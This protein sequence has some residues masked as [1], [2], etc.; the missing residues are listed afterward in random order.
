MKASHL[1]SL[2]NV[3]KDSVTLESCLFEK[4]EYLVHFMALI[5]GINREHTSIEA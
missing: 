4:K 1:A 2:P 3:E 5:A